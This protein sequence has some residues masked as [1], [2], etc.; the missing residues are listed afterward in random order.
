[1]GRGPVNFALCPSRTGTSC[2]CFPGGGRACSP[3]APVAA[4]IGERADPRAN[5]S[6]LGCTPPSAAAPPAL[7][8]LPGSPRSETGAGTR[9]ESDGAAGPI[10]RCSGSLGGGAA[11]G[12]GPSGAGSLREAQPPGGLAGGGEVA[13]PGGAERAAAGQVRGARRREG[14]AVRESLPRRPRAPGCAWWRFSR[15]RGGS[16]AGA[17]PP[18]GR[19]GDACRAMCGGPEGLRAGRVSRRIAGRWVLRKRAFST[20]TPFH[21]RQ[22]PHRRPAAVKPRAPRRGAGSP[23]RGARSG[24]TGPR[25]RP[26]VFWLLGVFAGFLSPFTKK[27]KKKKRVPPPPTPTFKFIY[28][29]EVVTFSI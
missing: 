11:A 7:T 17:E 27:K 13:G 23:E 8:P 6:E 16:R 28:L 5:G 22:G 19:W 14:L 26:R 21:P 12:R 2:L 15:C 1:M 9:P 24:R 29:I 4:R 3:A 18:R 20:V 10:A 25:Q